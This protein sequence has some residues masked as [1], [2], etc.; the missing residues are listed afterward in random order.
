[1]EAGRETRPP[2]GALIVIAVGLIASA[3][4][5]VLST[6][7]PIGAAEVEWDAQAPISASKP[8]AIPGGGTMRIGQA[9]LRATAPNGGGYR[10][11][12]IAA[13][14]EVSRGAA[15]GHG[16]ARCLVQIPAQAL[17]ARTPNG[18]AAY[19]QPSEDLVDQPVARNV[20]IEFGIEGTDLAAVSLGDAFKHFASEPG[21]NTEWTKYQPTRQGWDW[22]LPG[23]RPAQPLTLAFATVLRASAKPTARIACTVTTG[24]GTVTA[25]TFGTL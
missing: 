23:G 21:V 15:V 4:A 14:L 6:D 17:V 3:A 18:R 9:G 11:Y 1:M 20:K 24:A 19:P 5:A 13:A 10:L 8:V 22:G 16:R 25:R 12:R 7:E 2:R